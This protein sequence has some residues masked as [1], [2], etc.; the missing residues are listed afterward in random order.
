[1]TS[2]QTKASHDALVAAKPNI[3]RINV[4][5][6]PAAA[7]TALTLKV[8]ESGSLFLFDVVPTTLF[9]V[10]LPVITALDI[11][12]YFDFA[13][14]LTAST[15]RN[16]DCGAGATFIGGGMITTTTGT[17]T[18]G[19]GQQFV[20]SSGADNRLV[21]DDNATGEMTI[22]STWRFIAISTTVW[23]MADATIVTGDSPTPG[24]LFAT[25]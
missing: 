23:A 1:M 5:N 4:I 18:A 19:S 13:V 16:V 20:A 7:T 6:Q 10:T 11:G 24:D 17:T 14:T 15:P 8:S 9:T 22:G 2:F 3:A 25:V 12:T 21:I